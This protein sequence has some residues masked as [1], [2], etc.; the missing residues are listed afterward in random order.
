MK[1]ADRGVVGG[2]GVMKALNLNAH[3]VYCVYNDDRLRAMFT[4][5]RTADSRVT[6]PLA[7]GRTLI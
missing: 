1:A 5:L 2:G 3:V 7:F 6:A 4:R